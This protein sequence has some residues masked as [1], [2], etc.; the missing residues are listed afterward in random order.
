MVERVE[1]EYE[2]KKYEKASSMAVSLVKKIKN[3]D[4]FQKSGVEN[5]K[6]SSISQN[7]DRFRSTFAR[8]IAMMR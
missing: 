5:L 7:F 4:F 2:D 8:C 1:D 6:K 3:F